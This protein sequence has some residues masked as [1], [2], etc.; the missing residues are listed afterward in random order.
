[1]FGDGRNEGLSSPRWAVL[2]I[3]TASYQKLFTRSLILCSCS[4]S[5]YRSPASAIVSA[6]A[7]SSRL[8]LPSHSSRP[9]ALLQLTKM[10]SI[11]FFTNDSCSARIEHLDRIQVATS[12]FL[13]VCRCCSRSNRTRQKSHS[14]TKRHYQLQYGPN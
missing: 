4:L 14:H 6:P 7:R 8:S 9:C 1:M 11:L 3:L 2:I 12:P 5:W 13:R 10:F